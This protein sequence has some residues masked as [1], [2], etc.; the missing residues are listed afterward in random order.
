MFSIRMTRKTYK[1]IND[2]KWKTI[3]PQHSE[4][5]VYIQDGRTHCS[6]TKIICATINWESK[7]M[8]TEYLFPFILVQRNVY[9]PLEGTFW[10]VDLSISLM[11]VLIAECLIFLFYEGTALIR[12]CFD[13]KSPWQE[14][15]YVLQSHSIICKK[16][17]NFQ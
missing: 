12:F 9:S 1:R 17:E 6:I 11:Q 13:Q 2:M 14:I 5:W 8:L 16:K 15:Q 4:P 10:S 7:A 3:N